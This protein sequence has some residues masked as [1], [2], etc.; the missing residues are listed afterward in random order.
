MAK[1]GAQKGNKNARQHGFYS[2]VMSEEEKAQLEEASRVEGID[3]EISL[4]RVRLRGVMKEHP[5]RIDVQM[6]VANTIARMLRT[7]QRVNKEQKKPLME[8]IA[9]VLEDV[10]RPLG[11]GVGMGV[12]LKMTGK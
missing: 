1:R 10:A 6:E 4:L 9:R 12:G 7:R 8:A 11:I 2:T 3:E 5:E